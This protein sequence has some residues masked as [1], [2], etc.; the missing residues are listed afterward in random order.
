[1]WLRHRL[2]LHHFESWRM[3]QQVLQFSRSRVSSLLHKPVRGFLIQS[4]DLAR[5]ILELDNLQT[6]SN[7]AGNGGRTDRLPSGC[8]VERPEQPQDRANSVQTMLVFE[9]NNRYAC[10]PCPS[11]GLANASDLDTAMT[12]SGSLGLIRNGCRWRRLEGTCCCDVRDKVP[13]QYQIFYLVRHA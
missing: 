12:F 11:L 9:K 5:T 7:W 4:F 3:W 2:L 8:D 6:T 13:L 10:G 1:M